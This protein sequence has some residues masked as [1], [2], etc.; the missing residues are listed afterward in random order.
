MQLLSVCKSE[1]SDPEPSEELKNSFLSQ[2][3]KCISGKI[4]QIPYRIVVHQEALCN[5]QLCVPAA[6]LKSTI[7][8]SD[9]LFCISILVHVE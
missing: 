2:S 5:N 4:L 8:R 9:V 7:Y 1:T 6:V 3:V